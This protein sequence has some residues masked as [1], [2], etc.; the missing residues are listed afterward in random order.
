MLGV[1]LDTEANGLNFKKHWPIEIAIEIFD[2]ANGELKEKYHSLIHISPEDFAKSD[3]ESLSFTGIT[4]DELKEGKTPDKIHEDLLALFKKHNVVRR[5]AFFICQNP[6]F[7]RMFFSK[8]IPTEEQ[9]NNSFPYIWLD[10]AS[11]QWSRCVRDGVPIEKVMLSKD[12]IA[13]SYDVPP[14]QKPHRAQNGVRHLVQCYEK[15]V[16]FSRK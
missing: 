1:F 6:S 10:L 12:A 11:M 8:I 4:Y 3:P 2:L 5:K 15:V 9:E 7:D 13:E 16:G 14:E